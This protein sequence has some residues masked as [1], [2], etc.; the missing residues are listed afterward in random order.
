MKVLNAKRLAIAIVLLAMPAQRFAISAHEP[1]PG[2]VDRQLI[3][4]RVEGRRVLQEKSRWLGDVE[5][6]KRDVAAGGVLIGPCGFA[7]AVGP[8]GI[9]DDFT[10]RSIPG[11][12]ASPKNKVTVAPGSVVFMNT[13]QNVGASDDTFLLTA[14]TV[15]A[16]FSVELSLDDGSTYVSLQPGIGVR[17]RL[18]YRA[19]SIVSVRI[20]APAGIRALKGFDT[21]IRAQSTQTPSAVNDTINRLYTGFVQLE[22]RV[23]VINR[24][25]TGGP[26]DPVP[27]AM[28]EF[29]VTYRN[30][31]TRIG[32]G[33]SWLTAS[34]LVINEDGRGGLNNWGTTTEHIVGA[35]DSGTGIVTGDFP[36]SASLSDIVTSLGPG[37][38]G[39]FKFRRLIK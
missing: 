5:R 13:V 17:L 29:A 7:G 39:V 3:Q 2:H 23:E 15:P 20:T 31:T 28:L 11:G 32:S 33:S 16:G 12:V 36:G 4:S 38:S 37:E 35:S 22:T 27:G 24:T 21:V 34:N 30:V 6:A 10:N 9:D 25:G 14:P 26:N 8:T 19:A 18:A 1:L